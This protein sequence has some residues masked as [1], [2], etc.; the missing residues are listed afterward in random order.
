[1]K[2]FKRLIVQLLLLP[3]MPLLEKGKKGND[4]PITAEE[5]ANAE[6]ATKNWNHYVNSLRP[7][8]LEY[9]KN[10]SASAAPGITAGQGMANADLQQKTSGLTVDPTKGGMADPFVKQAEAKSAIDLSV[11]AAG[12][13]QKAVETQ[14]VLDV[15]R[16]KEAAARESMANL[17]Q[18]AVSQQLAAD[19]AEYNTD[20]SNAR[21]IV[22]GMGVAA[23][24]YSDSF[25][26]KKE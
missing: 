5:R 2:R 18:D 13:T 6:V 11:A 22:G 19:E 23:G 10:T 3:V 8:T 15:G 25:D 24:L 7:A 26:K 12:N 4:I 20:A 1:M 16:G 17:A 9:V 21:S 14:G